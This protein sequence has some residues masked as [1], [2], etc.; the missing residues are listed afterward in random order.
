MKPTLVIALLLVPTLLLGEES[1]ASGKS[2]ASD[3]RHRCDKAP[4]VW[5]GLQ[6]SR[7]DESTTIHLPDL[8]PGIGFTVKSIDDGG[9]AQQAGLLELD[10][11][12]RMGDQLLANEAQFATLLRLS[13]PG[14]VITLSGFRA[15]K[16]LEVKLTLGEAPKSDRPIP[17]GFVDEVVLDGKCGGPMRIV[18]LSSKTASFN[19]DDGRAEIRKT[20]TGYLVKIQDPNE[21][22]IFEGPLDQSGNLDPIPEDWRRRVHALRRGLDHSLE[23]GV[24]STRQPRPR[25][26]PPSPR[27][28]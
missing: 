18:N 21:K 20:D 11:L 25:V 6:I 3:R 10:V 26:V 19:T 4:E 2:G 1:S 27:N 16:P 28:P 8:P 17:P 14:D 22:T 13:K 15:G 23:N 5:L 24:A 7:P 9:P 12:C